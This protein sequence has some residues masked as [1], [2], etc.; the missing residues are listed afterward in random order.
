MPCNRQEGGFDFLGQ[1]LGQGWVRRK[2]PGETQKKPA[3][4]IGLR[5]PLLVNFRKILTT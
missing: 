4:Q 2:E 3:R 5:K 1:G